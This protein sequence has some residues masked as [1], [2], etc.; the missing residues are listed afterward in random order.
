M[1]GLAKLVLVYLIIVERVWLPPPVVQDNPFFQKLL[2]QVAEDLELFAYPECTNLNKAR[3]A[4]E[5]TLN[6]RAKLADAKKFFY[7]D[8]YVEGTTCYMIWA[9]KYNRPFDEVCRRNIL[10]SYGE[11]RDFWKIV[12][13]DNDLI[14]KV[15]D[16]LDDQYRN[17]PLYSKRLKLDAL[18]EILGSEAYEAGW[19]PN[20][21][22]TWRFLP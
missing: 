10:Q 18:R 7:I 14:Y 12:Q 8:F 13:R 15:Y 22:P 4:Y 17:I 9:M 2:A 3:N 11:S 21:T 16:L 1:L 6:C 5:E 20:P 19:L